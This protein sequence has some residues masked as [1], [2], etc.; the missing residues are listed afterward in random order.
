V[1]YAGH[2]FSAAGLPFSAFK[3][4][5]F[6]LGPHSWKADVPEGWGINLCSFFCCIPL[7]TDVNNTKLVLM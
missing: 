5:A 2:A 4:L 6:M 1:Y 3:T 7:L